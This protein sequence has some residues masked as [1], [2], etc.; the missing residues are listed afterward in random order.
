MASSELRTW[1]RTKEK[2]GERQGIGDEGRV[3]LL[4]NWV[5]KAPVLRIACLLLILFEWFGRRA[6][7]PGNQSIV[8]FHDLS[9]DSSEKGRRKWR[10]VGEDRRLYGP[11]M[12]TCWIFWRPALGRFAE[13]LLDFH[14]QGL[15]FCRG[16][17]FTFQGHSAECVLVEYI[18]WKRNEKDSVWVTTIGPHWL[19]VCGW[20]KKIHS[21]S[22][23]KNFFV[24]V[25]MAFLAMHT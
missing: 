6:Y 17:F 18:F 19:H 11:Y 15:V 3:L 25:A 4:V 12:R 1:P 24:Y 2:D 23:E 10:C 14:E 8:P 22:K 7:P 21:G 5:R 13:W 9:T 20:K 16:Y